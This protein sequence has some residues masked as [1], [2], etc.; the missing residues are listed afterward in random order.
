MSQLTIEDTWFAAGMKGTGSNTI[1]AQEVFVPDHRILPAAGLLRDDFPTPH[2]NEGLYRSS[3]MPA[4]ALLLIGPLLGLATRALELVIEN[5]P[6]RAIAYT[7]YAKQSTAPTFQLAIA[8]AATL[9]DTAHL[10][11]YRAA[12][13][14]D[15]A[16]KLGKKIGYV[17]RAR[18]LA[19]RGCLGCLTLACGSAGWRGGAWCADAA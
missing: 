10:H 8:K 2:K 9:V 4:A 17:E 6:K 15:N 1:V 14:I 13:A 16:A 19:S 7:F 3:F 12:D 18:A 5:A 11:A